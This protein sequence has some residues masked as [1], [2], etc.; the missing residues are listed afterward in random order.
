MKTQAVRKPDGWY[1]KA[2]ELLDSLNTDIVDL[3]IQILNV[4][5]DKL[6]YKQLREL[7][8]FEKYIKDQEDAV[9]P[10]EKSANRDIFRKKYGYENIKNF[11]EAVKY[12]IGQK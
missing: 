12:L 3:D 11:A 2:T 8:I 4:D 5:Y 6:E 1:V 7:A 10:K 9:I